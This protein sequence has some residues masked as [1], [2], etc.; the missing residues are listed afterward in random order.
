MHAVLFAALAAAFSMPLSAQVPASAPRGL[1]AFR[2]IEVAADG[3]ITFRMYASEAKEVQVVGEIVTVSGRESLPMT[4]DANGVWSTKLSG[5]LPETYTYS[6]RVDEL[7][8]Q[9]RRTSR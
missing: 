8:P 1:Q 4:K 2:P 3:T 5:M 6:Y 7:P 9:T